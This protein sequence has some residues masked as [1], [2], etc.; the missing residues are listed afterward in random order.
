MTSRRAAT[1]VELLMALTLL[2]I[3]GTAAVAAIRIQTGIRLRVGSRVTAATRVREALAPLSVDLM[4]L[5]PRGGDVIPDGATDSTLDVQATLASG[6]TC[7]PDFT[8]AGMLTVAFVGAAAPRVIAPGDTVRLRDGR[9]AAWRAVAIEG[10][11]PEPDA[12]RCVVAP[13]VVPVALTLD[14]VA[15]AGLGAGVPLHVTRRI[16]YSVYRASDGGTYLGLRAW[17]AATGRLSTVQPVAGP[18]GADGA[19][20]EYRDSLGRSLAPPVRSGDV[21]AVVVQLPPASRLRAAGA[22]VPAVRMVGVRNRR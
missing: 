13:E 16:R 5:S 19:R 22:G 17:S 18:F 8:G 6:Y 3:I 12:A 11:A 10:V 7:A 2:G 4:A 1:L 21:A 20:F 9:S 15:R 14:S